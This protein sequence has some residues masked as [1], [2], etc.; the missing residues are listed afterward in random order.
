MAP[1]GMHSSSFSALAV[2]PHAT[3]LLL[4]NHQAPKTFPLHTIE[5]WGIARILLLSILSIVSYTVGLA[6]Q[7]RAWESFY[8]TTS[9]K[10]FFC[11]KPGQNRD[12]ES[13][14]NSQPNTAWDKLLIFMDVDTACLDAPELYKVGNLLPISKDWVL[15]LI[16]M[17]IFPMTSASMILDEGNMLQLQANAVGILTSNILFQ[18]EGSHMIL[19]TMLVNLITATSIVPTE[20]GSISFSAISHTLLCCGSVWLVLSAGMH[21][22]FEEIAWYRLA[23]MP[24]LSAHIV[25]FSGFVFSLLLVTIGIE[26]ERSRSAVV[27]N[28]G[29]S[30]KPISECPSPGLVNPGIGFHKYAAYSSAFFDNDD[31][32]C[33]VHDPTYS[34]SLRCKPSTVHGKVTPPPYERTVVASRSHH[35]SLSPLDRTLEVAEDHK[36]SD[37]V[38]S[39]REGGQQASIPK[40]SADHLVTIGSLLTSTI[41]SGI[42][43]VFCVFTLRVYTHIHNRNATL[44]WQVFVC[45]LTFSFF[46]LHLNA[47]N[48]GL[49]H[50][51]LV[52][53]F[54]LYTTVMVIANVLF[55]AL[56]VHQFADS[57]IMLHIITGE[58]MGTFLCGCGL[59][60]G[61]IA[62]LA[63]ASNTNSSIVRGLSAA[64]DILL[65][66]WVNV[67]VT[68]H[69][70]LSPVKGRDGLFNR[71]HSKSIYTALFG[72]FDG[73][74]SSDYSSS[75]RTPGDGSSSSSSGYNSSVERR[76]YNANHARTDTINWSESEDEGRSVGGSSESP[77]ASEFLL[78]D[79]LLSVEG[80]S[81]LLPEQNGSPYYT[82]NNVV[83]GQVASTT[84]SLSS[85]PRSAVS[86]L[87]PGR[88]ALFQNYQMSST[89]REFGSQNTADMG[90]TPS[91][92]SCSPAVGPS[93]SGYYSYQNNSVILTPSSDGDSSASS[94]FAEA[95]NQVGDFQA[96]LSAQVSGEMA[97]RARNK[98]GAD[99]KKKV[100]I[101]GKI[102]PS[103]T[104]E[105][106]VDSREASKG[107]MQENNTPSLCDGSAGCVLPNN[108]RVLNFMRTAN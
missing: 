73:Y 32:G 106:C 86:G 26:E 92:N 93:A 88:R 46:I 33:P 45:S 27:V 100:V 94:L 50:F 38:S 31:D 2:G 103:K 20:S 68:P 48:W 107:E 105:T 23:A 97:E 3:S 47:L 52:V 8:L 58:G 10:A 69:P 65:W 63:T 16:F 80:L 22:F 13:R 95:V 99:Q 49:R 53:Y 57:F 28:G 101:I 77:V 81:N 44:S 91:D 72:R 12:A 89:A 84:E 6:L 18:N 74:E 21:P 55:Y 30:V 66:E 108:G 60:I 90:P 83:T 75:S 87:T 19:L 71:R 76:T 39:K 17:T 40:E 1:S 41:Q 51:P 29:S 102:N 7:K 67:S 42:L 37:F 9:K 79:D 56:V 96:N 25:V 62:N 70:M 82:P 98:L 24:A 14:R 11:S 61:A 43:G 59:L 35:G 5:D 85:G 78:D 104:P 54:P 15:G 64:K 36:N 4:P 34:D